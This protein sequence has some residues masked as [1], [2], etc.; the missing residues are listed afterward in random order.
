[1]E[2]ITKS[3][4]IPAYC[5][6]QITCRANALWVQTATLTW[7]DD[8]NQTTKCVFTGSGEKKELMSSNGTTMCPL[9][10]RNKDYSI[11]CAFTI[12]GD[13]APKVQDPT[14]STDG[15]RTRV[16]IRTED[17]TDNDYNDTWLTIELLPGVRPS[18][19]LETA[20]PEATHKVGQIDPSDKILRLELRDYDGR[21]IATGLIVPS[22]YQGSDFQRG[23]EYWYLDTTQDYS[24]KTATS[25]Q[26]DTSTTTTT[27]RRAEDAILSRP[28]TVHWYAVQAGGPDLADKE[29]GFGLSLTAKGTGGNNPGLDLFWYH[30]S[31]ENLSLDGQSTLVPRDATLQTSWY[32]AE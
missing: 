27:N 18:T 19:A 6:G 30:A 13:K 22:K 4:A 10:P 20:Q 12:V 14:T 8:N 26:I 2:P 16:E 25:L 11:Q 5:L 24:T 1:M 17:D 7:E 28:E 23:T 3:I 21:L 9:P 31:A 15:Q 29:R 32:V